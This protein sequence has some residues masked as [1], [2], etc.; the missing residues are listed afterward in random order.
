MNTRTVKCPQCG[1]DIPLSTSEYDNLASQI[2][3][4][5]IEEADFESMDRNLL[6]ADH[7]A[8]KMTIKRLT[9]NS[10][11][12]AELIDKSTVDGTDDEDP[13]TE[14]DTEEIINADGSIVS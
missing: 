4:Q 11:S 2:R 6:T 13:D 10:P 1:A 5:V 14:P 7:K 3:Q 9:R 8:Q 12:V